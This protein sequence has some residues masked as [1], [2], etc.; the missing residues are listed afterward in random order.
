MMIWFHGF[1]VGIGCGILFQRELQYRRVVHDFK[2]S[3]SLKEQIGVT[4][5]EMKQLRD[6]YKIAD[7]QSSGRV[8]TDEIDS[9]MN[10]LEDKM[11]RHKWNLTE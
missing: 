9:A 7:F 6:E 4:E 8:R 2:N 10:K 1:V 3:L 11:L 5:K